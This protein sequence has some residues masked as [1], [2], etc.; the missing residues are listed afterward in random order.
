MLQRAA[1]FSISTQRPFGLGRAIAAVLLFL[2]LVSAQRQTSA[3]RLI[4]HRGG[5]VSERFAENS[6]ASMEEAVKR[7]Y[8]MIEVDVRGSKDGKLVVQ[9]DPDFKRFY[10]VDREVA[11][12]AWPEIER[13]RARPGD[14]RP[15]TFR[16]L[17]ERAKGRLHLMIDTKPPDH[18]DAFYIE[19]ESALRDNGLLETAYIIGTEESRARLK[20]KA[21][22]SARGDELQALARK[23]EQLKHYF[24]FEW[25]NMREDTVRWAQAHHVPVVPSINTFHYS[26]QDPVKRGADDI[27]RLRKL[28]VTEFQIDSVYDNLFMK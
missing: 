14:T 18:P 5:V 6:P 7:G 8:W 21:R 22:I 15:M 12:M 10:G 19:L 11:S 2:T 3:I 23:G 28:G 20:G 27:S 9:H 24:V 17:C 25:G 26:E 1:A 13:L 4:A 16:E